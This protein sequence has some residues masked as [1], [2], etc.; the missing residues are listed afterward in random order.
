MGWGNAEGDPQSL[1]PLG[2]ARRSRAQAASSRFGVGTQC[3][4]DGCEQSR[5]GPTSEDAVAEGRAEQEDFVF[6]YC[7]TLLFGGPLLTKG[8]LPL[9]SNQTHLLSLEIPQK[10]QGGV[11]GG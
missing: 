6:P 10:G 1:Q 7:Q 4:C 8:R 2:T 3:P 11:C 5:T 9:C